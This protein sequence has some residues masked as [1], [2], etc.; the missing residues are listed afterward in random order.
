ME[1]NMEATGI[2]MFR[3]QG[4]GGDAEHGASNGN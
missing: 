1:Q 3:V 2:S 4:D